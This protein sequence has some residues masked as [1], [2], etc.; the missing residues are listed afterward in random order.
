M[1]QRKKSNKLRF[2]HFISMVNTMINKHIIIVFILS[3]FAN[4]IFACTTMSPSGSRLMYDRV[5][6]WISS[7]AN[8]VDAG[9][10]GDQLL[11]LTQQAVDQ[12]WNK[13]SSSRLRFV[14]A[15]YWNQNVVRFETGVLCT[16]LDCGN[17]T[18]PNTNQVIITCNDNTA[19][20]SSTTY[21]KTS[22]IVNSDNIIGA[23]IL[24]NNTDGTVF[25]DLTEIQKLWVIGHEL[26]HAAGLGHTKNAAN[27]MYYTLT[28]NRETLGEEDYWGMSFLYPQNQDGC[29]LIGSINKNQ[30]NKKNDM[31]NSYLLWIS[32]F[33]IGIMIFIFLIIFQKVLLKRFKFIF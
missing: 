7:D 30:D 2:K 29:G 8:C 13:I 17:S 19:N 27:L 22:I 1:G 32:N 6:V 18:V 9:V 21:A 24:I 3:S 14:V 16:T 20:F 23:N 4:Q 31:V 15:G 10:N 26:G 11:R 28:P 33:L 25:A 12:F 5:D